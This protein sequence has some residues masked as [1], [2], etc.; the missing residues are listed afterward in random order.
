MTEDGGVRFR[1]FEL[2]QHWNY[3]LCMIELVKEEC[4]FKSSNKK[5]QNFLYCNLKDCV[6]NIVYFYKYGR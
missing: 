5:L 4:S 6:I 1:L 2:P 3:Y